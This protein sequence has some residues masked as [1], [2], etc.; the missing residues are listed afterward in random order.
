MDLLM[1]GILSAFI[2]VVLMI[3]YFRKVHR[4]MDKLAKEVSND[5]VV[6]Q[7]NISI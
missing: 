2:Y 5:R 4:V 1:L 6:S 7:L 3:I